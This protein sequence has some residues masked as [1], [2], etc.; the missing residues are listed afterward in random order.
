MAPP[1]ADSTPWMRRFGKASTGSCSG[2]M[3][4]RGNRRRR[5]YDRGFV[6][7][8]HADWPSLLRTIGETGARRALL[9]HGYSDV[10]V[11]YLCERGLDAGALETAFGGE[12]GAAEPSPEG[13]ED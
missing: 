13:A 11:R 2:W 12:E 8:D 6:L 5:G 7:S 4:V 1:G 10:L 3:R 9:T